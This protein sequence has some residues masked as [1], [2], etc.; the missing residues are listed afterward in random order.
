[1]NVAY[2]MF[3]HMDIFEK[4]LKQVPFSFCFPEYNGNQFNHV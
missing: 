3:T 2:V 1:V 4:K